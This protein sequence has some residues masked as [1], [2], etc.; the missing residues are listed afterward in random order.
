FRLAGLC[1]AGPGICEDG[2]D[3]GALRAW[4]G[5]ST[6]AVPTWLSRVVRGPVNAAHPAQAST[7]RKTGSRG[8]RQRWRP[9]QDP[10]LLPIR[11]GGRWGP[12]GAASGPKP[13]RTAPQWARSSPPELSC[14]DASFG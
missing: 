8:N 3:P 4:A 9:I 14:G 5:D 2:A 1:G 11:P 13:E 6:A 7:N 10:R 12:P